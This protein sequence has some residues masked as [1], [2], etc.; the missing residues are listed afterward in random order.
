MDMSSVTS[1]LPRLIAAAL[2]AA[3]LG[4]TAAAGALSLSLTPRTSTEAQLLST[5][6][7]LYALRRDLRAGADI[8]QR[9]QGHAAALL[10]SG[11]GQ[12]AIIRQRGAD[13]S[14]TLSQTG[15]P[16][17]QVIM[18]FGRG[19]QADIAQTGGQA[20]ILLQFAP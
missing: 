5:A 4:T 11:S 7:T 9:G 20:G 2:I 1:R 13:H 10:Q 15:A 19:A 18:Q 14:A 6:I 17:A 16:N 3:S 12:R 8:G